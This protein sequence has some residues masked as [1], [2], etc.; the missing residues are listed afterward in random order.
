[1]RKETILIL[2][3]GSQYNQLIVRRVRELGV[4]SE[5]I[6][7]ETP[8]KKILALNPKGFILSGGP[9]SVY[10]SNAPSI[11]SKILT[12][13]L[14]IL[15]ICYGMQ[16]LAQNFGGAVVSGE[17][18]E[19]GKNK[20][21]VIKKEPLFK[22]I[23]N[24]SIGWMSHGDAVEKIPLNFE[25]LALSEYNKIAAIGDLK[26]NIFGLQFHPEVMHTAYGKEIIKNFLEIC[27]CSFS[28]NTKSFI[29]ETLKEIKKEIK[30][31][32]VICAFSG[33][34]D[35]TVAASLV[36]KIAG[37]NLICI[38]VD[39]GLLRLNEIKFIIE[40][41][42]K[43]TNLK[44]KSVNFEKHF[45]KKLKGVIDPEKKRRIIGR[46]FI[47]VF[48][49]EA[50]KIG[51]VSYL[52][53]GTLYPDVIE[54]GKSKGKEASIIKTHHNVGAL[55]LKMKFKLIEPLKYLFKDEVREAGFSLGLPKEILLRQPF[56]GPGLAVRIIG[57]VTKERLEVLR[58]ADNIFQE[59][60]K[61]SN[62]QGNIWQY[63]AVL[64]PLKTVGVMGDKRT[65]QE[66]IA[67]RAVTCADGMTADI[68]KI[69]W[70]VLQKISTRIVNEVKGINRVVYD[71]TSKPP[72][73]IEWE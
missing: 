49:K 14:P 23:P 34:V 38:L 3:Y 59:E 25:I 26:R 22:R 62:L 68:A 63:F 56:P 72:G 9:A 54:S 53:Q 5:L 17:K 10:E 6:S 12:I 28:W 67:I 55:P 1:M 32:K 37:N 58:L 33:G 40:T 48:E 69:P 36:S 65:Y 18:R 39:N 43:F 51:K 8:W 57:E 47:K 71:L 19:Y 46:E 7:L 73:T 4:Y 35:S 24:Q 61:L 16:L 45:L 64:L 41:L 70:K 27:K 15:G 66:I 11:P 2:D 30:N 13:G 31:K 21:K 60:I 52:V 29:E 50:G 42:S 20:F 44:I